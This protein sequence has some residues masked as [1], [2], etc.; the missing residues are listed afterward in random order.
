[1]NKF[2]TKISWHNVTLAV[3][4]FALGY[5]LFN[6]LQSRLRSETDL[7][8]FW[9]VWS[10]LEKKYPFE[11][12]S[13]QDK[14]YGAIQGL[15][16]SYGDEYS[17]FLPPVRSEFFNQTIHGEFGGIGAEIS[18]QSGYLTIVSP[19]K[20]SPAE[21][22]N[23]LAGDIVT[24]VDGVEVADKTLDEAIGLIRGEIGTEV[25]LTIIRR[26][27]LEPL[28]I[29]ITRDNVKIPILD[30][31]VQGDVFIIQLYNF[32]ETSAQEFKYALHEFN[33]GGY[34]KL[35]IDVR[36]NPG[37][38]LTSAI[39]IVGYFLPQGK[40]VLREQGSQDTAEEV[41]RSSGHDLL[42]NENITLKV[43]ING[44][45]ASAS[46]ILAGALQDH[47][48]AVIIGEQSFGKGSV[49]ELIDLPEKTSLKI[50]T[51]KWLTPAGNHISRIGITPD[52]EIAFNPE[53]DTQL[54]EALLLFND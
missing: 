34:D 19:L 8:L 28:D 12:P 49:Q 39:D 32:N 27:E 35:L 10:T 53:E 30:T 38:Y 45:S 4:F 9:D 11:E 51:A 37:G 6:P 22:A 52:I 43:L 25:I 33:Q 1:M 3:V 48:K 36:N 14:V 26:G 13:S 47:K 29:T 5:F 21:K 40:V 18:I 46:E 54:A 17:S 44:G 41:Y 7:D 16:D 15:V 20:D 2:I 42:D 24:H 50:T 31:Q 23:V